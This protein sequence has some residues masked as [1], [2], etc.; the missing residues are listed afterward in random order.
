MDETLTISEI[1]NIVND[2]QCQIY[3]NTGIEYYD[4]TLLSNGFIVI[5]EFCGIQLWNSDDDERGWIM[6][7]DIDSDEEFREGLKT[8]IIRRIKQEISNISKIVLT[9]DTD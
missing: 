9:D 3:D 4:L 1:E 2:L 8:F 5:I 6:D 7:D